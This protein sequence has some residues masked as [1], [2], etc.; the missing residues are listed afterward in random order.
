MILFG[1]PFILLGLIILGL[2]VER[3]QLNRANRFFRYRITVNGT[4]G[5]SSVT[6]YIAAGL[7]F[8]GV[9][10]FGKITGIIP[11]MYLPDGST[12][13]IKRRGPARVQE[14]VYMQLKAAA[15]H[16]QAVVLECMSLN[17]EYQ[18]LESKIFR[19]H[20]YV[21]TNIGDDHREEMGETNEERVASICS[22][23]PEGCTVI[24]ADEQNFPLIAAWAGKKGSACILAEKYFENSPIP[25]GI[26]IQNLNLAYTVIA[27][28][29]RDNE[30]VKEQLLQYCMA[31]PSSL[32]PC[33]IK[34]TAAWFLN[35]FP[36]NDVPSAE[37]FIAYWKTQIPGNTPLYLV[38]NTR[39]DRPKRT[40][41]FCD[42][43]AVSR[44]F[45]AIIIT[46]THKEKAERLLTRRGLTTNVTVAENFTNPADARA[47]LESVVTAPAM[48]I[49]IGNIAGEGFILIE[50][51][52]GQAKEQ[53]L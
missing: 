40:R 28:L 39:A 44:L 50:A 29:G 49:G 19:P 1:L 8:A 26:F 53:I 52:T 20:I 51:L 25:P 11:T 43:L 16:C 42:W 37:K 41:L 3:I 48:I 9:A 17:P 21:I 10:T 38:L 14:Q 36:V 34:E 46:G 7:R 5:K 23:I 22:A 24:T 33:M 47:I 30:L 2:V 45:D 31:Q 13:P 32:T 18:R 35:G 6:T 12:L 15:M 4:R 27:C